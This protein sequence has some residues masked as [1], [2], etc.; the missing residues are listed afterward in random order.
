MVQLLLAFETAS[1]EPLPPRQF[2]RLEQ[3]RLRRRRGCG[4]SRWMSEEEHADLK[5]R[6]ERVNDV[7]RRREAA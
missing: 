3:A 5:M 4:A 2:F 7:R 1:F 6:M